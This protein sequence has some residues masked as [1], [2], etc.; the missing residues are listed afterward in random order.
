MTQTTSRQLSRRL[1]AFVAFVFL[2]GV[3]PAGASAQVATAEDDSMRAGRFDGGKMWT[4]E[5]APS[6]YFTETYGFTADSAWFARARLSALRIPGCSAAFVSPNGLV[7][8]NHHC[9]RGAQTRVQREGESLLD[10]G[11]YARSLSEERRI[12]NYWADQLLAAE[13]VTEEVNRALMGVPTGER[14]EATRTALVAIGERLAAQYRTGDDSV[15][16]QTVP[17]YNGGRHSAYVF[18][19]Y[20]D[21]RLAFAVELQAGFFGGDPDNFTYPRYALDFA[22][23]RIYGKNGRPI[24]TD[25]SF[26]WSTSGVQEG[27]VVFVIGNPGSTNRL[28][29]MA[30]LEY[31]HDVFL[32]AVLNYYHTRLDAMDA[33]RMAKP[34]EAE[35]Y[36]IRN[37]MFGLS[38]SLKATTGR[39]EA[40]NLPVVIA[41]RADA[42]RDLQDR[43]AADTAHSRRFGGLFDRMARLQEQRAAQATPLFAFL[44]LGTSSTISR[45]LW[46]RRYLDAMAA[47]A[48]EDSLAGLR[49]RLLGVDQAPPDLERRLL[50]ARLRDIATAYGPDHALTRAA[51]PDGTP[52]ASAAALMAHSV[53]GDSA[54]TAGAVG[55]NTLG[56]T[57]PALR[58][59]DAFLPLYEA[60]RAALAPIG[61]AES[62]LAAELGRA[63]F[64]VYGQRVPPDGT[65]SP[66]ITD[67]V[68]KG[69]PYNGT[70]A[71]PYTT[72]YGFY[73]RHFSH[74]GNPEWAVPARWG[75]PPEGLDLATPLNFV[76]TADTYGG[77]SGSPAV[78]KDLELVG[79]NFDRNIEGLSRDYI[80][81]PDRGRN[82]MVD[83]RAVR[84]ALQHV[85]HANRI[86]QELETGRL[87]APEPSR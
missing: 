17:L 71:P 33:Y 78:T 26:G 15:Y 14:E 85:Y 74:P 7:A 30:Q 1:H 41:K 50:A 18:R 27:D 55:E 72:L 52:E 80:Y 65:F 23:L 29:T 61:G 82:V 57:D 58:L 73:D 46:A 54:A 6:S 25:H 47:G 21:V 83:V 34:A 32:P 36:D 28:T 37:R 16:V 87:A 44:G 51:L 59:L 81:L 9:I 84:A 43:I 62:D 63:K 31:Q 8:T 20:T 68:V 24:H 60:Y 76:S 45:A 75:V 42:E 3:L 19:R 2:L 35:A 67:G 4:F 12:P 38:N 22:F 40:L 48:P 53:L 70:L 77:N 11:F 5:Y 64:A 39:L 10:N 79:L 49:R 56:G 13:D 69:Y 66:R 86:L